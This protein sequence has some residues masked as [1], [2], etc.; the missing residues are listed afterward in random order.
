MGDYPDAFTVHILPG[1]D[2][3]FVVGEPRLGFETEFFQALL[4]LLDN[5]RLY[6]TFVS[7]DHVSL[8]TWQQRE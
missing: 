3:S 2:Q 4:N 8:L 6:G 1:V 5:V 7:H